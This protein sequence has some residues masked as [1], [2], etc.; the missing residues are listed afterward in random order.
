MEYKSRDASTTS[1]P[2]KKIQV[3]RYYAFISSSV[4]SNRIIVLWGHQPILNTYPF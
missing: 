1:Y 2:F 3:N 4:Y